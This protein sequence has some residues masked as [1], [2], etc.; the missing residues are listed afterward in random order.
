MENT[1]TGS[2]FARKK[3]ELSLNINAKTVLQMT[4]FILLSVLLGQGSVFEEL[5]PFGFALITATSGLYSFLALL[6][7]SIGFLISHSGIFLFRYLV[8]A[9]SLW[10]IRSRVLNSHSRLGNIWFVAPSVCFLVCFMT[11]VAV[12]LPSGGGLDEIIVLLLRGLLHLFLPFFT[13]KVLS[14]L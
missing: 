8:C 14:F 11:G 13:E 12:V 4:G 2:F 5:Y 7:T 9:A 1:K 6:G 10:V 3:A